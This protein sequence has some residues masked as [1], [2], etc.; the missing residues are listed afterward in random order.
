MAGEAVQRQSVENHL[1]LLIQ[2]VQCPIVNTHMKT[3]RSSFIASLDQT[4]QISRLSRYA[5][6][7]RSH[8]AFMFS[9]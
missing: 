2:V 6:N 8:A 9:R 3:V 4:I 5:K 1:N 7:F